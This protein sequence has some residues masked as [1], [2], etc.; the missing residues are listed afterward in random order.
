MVAASSLGSKVILH[1]TPPTLPIKNFFCHLEPF[2]CLLLLFP[3]YFMAVAQA[4]GSEPDPLISKSSHTNYSH[5]FGST[6]S[7][8]PAP[9]PH[10]PGHTPAA[11]TGGIAELK[12]SM[13]QKIIASGCT[14][15]S[16]QRGERELTN[17]ELCEA[18]D[19]ILSKKPG[20]FLMRFGKHLGENDLT[21]FDGKFADNF[22][23]NFRLKELRQALGRSSKARVK[24]VKNRRYKCLKQLMEESD[25]FS[26]EEMR[27]RNPLLFEYYIGQFLSDDEKHRMKE[28]PTDM[29]LSSMILE[30]LR[31]DRRTKLLEQQQKREAEQEGEEFDS[32]SSSSSSEDE[33]D[34]DKVMSAPMTF[35]SNP[36]TAATERA[37]LSQEFLAAMQASFLNGTDKDFDYSKVDHNESY[38][39]L[40]MEDSDA[41]DNYFDS[42]EPSWSQVDDSHDG[43][44][45]GMAEEDSNCQNQVGFQTDDTVHKPSHNS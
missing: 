43:M 11:K 12:M 23:V 33:S 18:L 1:Q 38:D 44:E 5:L 34:T 19:V 29:K 3:G 14:I 35:S 32:S 30:N 20:A 42:E 27:H 16:Q 7:H 15:R 10:P 4:Q 45:L 25:Y 41:Q 24:T 22:E 36:E 37:L 17:V 6:S 28:K 21:Y 26:E 9:Q 2:C 40:D 13:F 31:V 8:D 39:S